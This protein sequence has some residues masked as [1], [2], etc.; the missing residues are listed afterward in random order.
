MMQNKVVEI[1]TIQSMKLQAL[2]TSLPQD[3]MILMLIALVYLLSLPLA[4][5][6]FLYIKLLRLKTKDK[7]MKNKIDHQNDVIC[8][9]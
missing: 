7:P 9:L 5:V 8:M 1:L 6:Y 4:F 3:Q 2:L